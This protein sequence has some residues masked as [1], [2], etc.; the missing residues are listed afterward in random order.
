MDKQEKAIAKN[1][2]IKLSS[3]VGNLYLN[4]KLIT[5]NL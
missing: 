3:V 2:P 5:Y 1:Y 4:L